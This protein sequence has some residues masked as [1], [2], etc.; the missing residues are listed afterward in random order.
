MNSSEVNS[1]EVNSSEVNSIDF[2][3][4]IFGKTL[5]DPIFDADSESDLFSSSFCSPEA[6]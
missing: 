5:L 3:H 4:S 1:I 2:V 6:V